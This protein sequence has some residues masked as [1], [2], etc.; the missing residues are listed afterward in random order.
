M[1]FA[2]IAAYFPLTDIAFGAEFRRLKKNRDVHDWLKIVCDM[3]PPM[4]LLSVYPFLGAILRSR[5]VK[6]C[7]LYLRLTQLA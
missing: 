6:K 5:V 3:L 1:D 7:I 4:L 2:H